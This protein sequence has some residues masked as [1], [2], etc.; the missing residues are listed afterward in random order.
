MSDPGVRQN[1]DLLRWLIAAAFAVA[2]WLAL[3]AMQFQPALAAVVL[4]VAVGGIALFST[5]FASVTLVLILSIP[6]VAANPIV[7]LV[8]L[9]AGVAL[10]DYLGGETVPP[11][12]FTAA[13]LVA[14]VLGPVWAVPVLA[15][16]V[17]GSASGAL[18]ALAACIVVELAAILLGGDWSSVMFLGGAKGIVAFADA[19]ENLLAFGWLSR[20]LG[21]ID[22]EAVKD[23]WSGMTQARRVGVLVIQPI[24]WA[25]AATV[26]GRLRR[27]A[28]HPRQIAMSVLASVAGVAIAAAASVAAQVAFGVEIEGGAVVVMGAVSVLVVLVGAVVWDRLFKV[29]PS[30]AALRAPTPIG[31]RGMASEDADVDELLRLIAS[32]EDKIANQHTTEAVVMITDMK[33]FSRMTEEEGSFVTAKAVQRHRDLLLPVIETRGGKGKSTGGDGLIASFD[34]AQNAVCA[35]IEMQQALVRYNAA[36]SR[37]REILV[38]VGIARGEVVLDKGGRPFIGAA[39]NL[40]ARVM[41][42]GDGGQVLVTRDIASRTSGPDV[43]TASHGEFELKNIAK[44]VEV[45]EVLWAEDQVP[46]DPRTLFA[47]AP[48]DVTEA[49]AE[50]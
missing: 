47:P 29:V 41:S 42:L 43:V 11:L 33:S 13:A 40:A 19:P 46:C 7:G 18:A 4:S 14:A 28:N 27:P 1:R 12:L 48:Q 17:L 50:S 49:P 15:G 22:M 44:P 5:R 16:Y 34:S 20:S 26:A 31:Q 10:T 3:T 32:A 24:A 23:V 21:A 25:L 39:L 9:V 36:H 37:E 45:L 2:G 35:A 8:F 30:P 38:R 6:L